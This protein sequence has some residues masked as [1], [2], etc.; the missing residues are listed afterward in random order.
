MYWSSRLTECY[1][2][3]KTCPLSNRSQNCNKSG[4][5]VISLVS[6]PESFKFQKNAWSQQL[7]SECQNASIPF[8]NPKSQVSR[9]V[10]MFLHT[11][12]KSIRPFRLRSAYNF[13]KKFLS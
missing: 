8:Q 1:I 11:F 9:V 6:K 2:I 5:G 4:L 13:F 3:F 7:I 10:Y 12:L